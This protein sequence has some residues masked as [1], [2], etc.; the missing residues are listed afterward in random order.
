MTKSAYPLKM[1]HSV[2]AA[3]ARLAKADG[4]SLNQFIAVAVAEKVG[5]LE[6]AA[7]FLRR[8]AGKAK[9]KDMLRHLRSAPNIGGN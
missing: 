2:K 5:T 1:P 9:P 6:T 7:E 8:R 3:A 4:V